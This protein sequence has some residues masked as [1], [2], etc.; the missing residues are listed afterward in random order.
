MPAF[1]FIHS[2]PSRSGS[3]GGNATIDLNSTPDDSRVAGILLSLSATSTAASGT[4][5]N[6]TTDLLALM[7]TIDID[8]DWAFV[9]ASGKLLWILEKAMRGEAVNESIASGTGGVVMRANCLIPFRDDRCISPNDGCVPA[10]L[11]KDRSV[12]IGFAASFA[13][14]LDSV[15]CTFTNVLVTAYALLEPSSGDVL[16]TKTRIGF[17]DWA[18]NTI[19][20]ANRGVVTDLGFYEEAMALT[21]AE[22]AQYSA[23]FNGQPLI[24]RV[25]TCQLVDYWNK[26][27]CRDA[28]SRLSYQPSASQ[29]FIPIYNAPDGYKATQLPRGDESTRIDID[30]GSQTGG[31]VF[32]RQIVP[33]DAG[34]E[35]D[36]LVKLGFDPA[37]AQIEVKTAKGNDVQGS[38]SRQRRIAAVIPRRISR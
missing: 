32:Y 5:A 27:R 17:E 36:A 22:H 25:P 11:I 38:S 35:R 24:D 2:L 34:T 21:L 9:R 13:P 26:R 16:P 4:P 29:Q 20:L 14:T 30:S 15:V 10:A 18:Q 1:K 7:T 12:N 31:R 3:A 23:A 33:A 37:T 8:S 28:A 6:T 19:N